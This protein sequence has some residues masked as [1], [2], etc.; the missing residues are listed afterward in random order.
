MASPRAERRRLGVG[1]GEADA[2]RAK[3]RGAR[4][5]KGTARC[6]RGGRVRARARAGNRDAYTPT[7]EPPTLQRAKTERRGGREEGGGGTW[8]P[9]ARGLPLLPLPIRASCCCSAASDLRSANLSRRPPA[10]PRLPTSYCCSVT[11]DLLLLCSAS[12]C[13]V[14]SDLLLLPRGI[15]SLFLP[16]FALPSPRSVPSGPLLR[17]IRPL[18]RP[19]GPRRPASARGR[20]ELGEGGSS[21]KAEKKRSDLFFCSPPSGLCFSVQSMVPLWI[22]SLPNL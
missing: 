16:F 12:C 21:E 15:S 17:A 9:A 14:T 18:L 6:A 1:H 8:I 11:S 5:K 20:R 4:V 10:S 2:A 22:C 7:R 3:S 19:S 13:S